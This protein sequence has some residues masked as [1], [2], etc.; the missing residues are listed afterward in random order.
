M[1][2]YKWKLSISPSLMKNTT[3]SLGP[4]IEEV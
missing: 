1:L 4:V 2:N 3:D